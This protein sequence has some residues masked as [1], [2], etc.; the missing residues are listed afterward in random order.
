MI[1]S[2]EITYKQYIREWAY[3][4]L[5]L[6]E[7]EG[8]LIMQYFIMPT[9][10]NTL[11]KQGLTENRIRYTYIIFEEPDMLQ[12]R[13][14]DKISRAEMSQ[15]ATTLNNI[16]PIARE[17]Y[18][19]DSRAYKTVEHFIKHVRPNLLTKGLYKS[20][21]ILIQDEQ[22]NMIDK[23]D[24]AG[25]TLP[26]RTKLDKPCGIEYDKEPTDTELTAWMELFIEEFNKLLW[27]VKHTGSRYSSEQGEYWSRGLRVMVRLMRSMNNDKYAR[28]WAEW[29][30][31]VYEKYRQS[32]HAASSHSGVSDELG[33]VRTV[34]RESITENDPKMLEQASYAC[35]NWI[36][37]YGLIS[38]S[39][40]V[41]NEIRAKLHNDKRPKLSEN[42]IG[43]KS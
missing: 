17:Q 2:N 13:I 18:D 7:I 35:E 11:R 25:I 9:I 28:N 43:H 26:Q 22:K 10:V 21:T 42:S 24:E 23:C 19:Y 33:R 34:T 29:L 32:K 31:I 14:S 36:G 39:F 1:Y 8:D 38:W 6:Y 15:L 16:A 40:D 5:E 4:L 41:Q 37:F 27:K 3:N 12:F 20:L 30:Q